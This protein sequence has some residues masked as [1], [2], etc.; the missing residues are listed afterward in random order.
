MGMPKYVFLTPKVPP[1]HRVSRPHVIHSL[2][3]HVLIK[4]LNGIKMELAN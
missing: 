3:V 2:G 1:F 4:A